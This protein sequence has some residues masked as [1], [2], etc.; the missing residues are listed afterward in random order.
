MAFSEKETSVGAIWNFCNLPTSFLENKNQNLKPNT[1]PW[2]S[3]N[4]PKRENSWGLFL[5][6]ART[7]QSS[8]LDKWKLNESSLGLFFVLGKDNGVPV[9]QG[10][11]K[12]T[13]V[14]LAFPSF[15]DRRC[16]CQWGNFL[17]AKRIELPCPVQNFSFQQ[18]CRKR[19]Q[20]LNLFQQTSD[21][22]LMLICS[23][24]LTIFQ[25]HITSC[26]CPFSLTQK[27]VAEWEW[28]I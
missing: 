20:V 15:L 28:R 18:A 22:H 27:T 7:W 14:E 1:F 5:Q 4:Y 25:W 13:K 10:H 9:T 16:L 11:W 19:N 24:L 12:E 8:G 3:N 26:S 21:L 17:Y 6:G 2:S 23:L